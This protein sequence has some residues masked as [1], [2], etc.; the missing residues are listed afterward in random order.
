MSL[1]LIAGVAGLI[2]LA[3]L[4]VTGKLLLDAHTEMGALKVKVAERDAIIAQKSHDAD[5]S[6]QLASFQTR[7]ETALKGVSIQTRQAITNA[8]NDNDAAAAAISGVQRLR[9]GS[10][11]SVSTP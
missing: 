1:W 2:L 4:G 11:G 7:I 5:L 9:A 3:A 8:P 6:D 10:R